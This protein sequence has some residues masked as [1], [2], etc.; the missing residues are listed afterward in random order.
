MIRIHKLL[1]FNL[2]VVKNSLENILESSFNIKF[3]ELINE[4]HLHAVPKNS[5][6]HF[7]AIIVA[8]DFEGKLPIERHQMVYKALGN[9]IKMVH[10]LSLICKNPKEWSLSQEI[11][12]SPKCK[13]GSSHEKKNIN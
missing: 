11:P 4:S 12:G 9:N 13:G 5:E 2:C 1:R 7:K 6:T 3:L 10:A 8:E